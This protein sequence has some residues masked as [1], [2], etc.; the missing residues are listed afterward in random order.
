MER[1]QIF[2]P[3]LEKKSTIRLEFFRHDEK[4]KESTAGP[5]PD[6]N[7]VRLTAIGRAHA[8][9]AGKNKNHHPEVAVAFGSPRERSTETALLQMLANDKGISDRM[10]LEEIE[11]YINKQSA[12]GKKEARTK[13]L[14]FYTEQG[15][16]Y[17]KLYYDHYLVKKDALNFIWKESDDLVKDNKDLNSLSYS[18]QAGNIAEIIQKYIHIFPQWQKII[19]ESPEKYQ[20]FDNEMQR[21]FGSHQDVLE[22][23]LMKIIEKTQ[24]AKSV[25]EFIKDLPDKNG[26]G[27][28]EGFSADIVEKNS[29]IVI[30]LKF[31]NR[32]WSIAPELLTQIIKERDILNKEI[33]HSLND[34]S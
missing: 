23:F 14:D 29:N 25:E 6:D 2:R 4:T 32:E 26:F 8:L 22:P 16:E 18:R 30:N 21:F 34:N 10:N 20:K 13:L 33:E 12:V 27:Y 31:K 17:H 3:E 9:E 15:S 24:G 5:R 7:T 1:E 28:S 11:N 19:K